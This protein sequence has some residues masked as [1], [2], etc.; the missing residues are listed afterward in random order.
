MQS[1][2]LSGVSS[3]RIEIPA[4]GPIPETVIR[5][6]KASSSATVAKAYKSI[7]SSRT[8]RWVYTLTSFPISASCLAVLRD[9]KHLNPMPPHST[10]MKF[11]SH[12]VSLPFKLYII[13]NPFI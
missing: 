11:A 6:L 9:V 3:E 5:S 4:L 10:T 1:A 13:T 2:S 12:T 8:A 7:A